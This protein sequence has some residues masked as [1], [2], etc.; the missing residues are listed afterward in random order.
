MLE[1][2]IVVPQKTWPGFLKNAMVPVL[3]LDLVTKLFL[4]EAQPEYACKNEDTN[5]T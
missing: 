2:V 4:Q 1:V 5:T 3:W